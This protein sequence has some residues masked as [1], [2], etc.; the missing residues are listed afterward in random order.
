MSKHQDIRTGLAEPEEIRRTFEVDSAAFGERMPEAVVEA[1]SKWSDP[2]RISVSRDGGDE[3][4]GVAVSIPTAVTLPGL[5]RLTA[6]AVVGVSVLPTHRRQGRLTAMMRHQLD[7]L[8]ERGEP[9]ATLYSSEGSIY[10]R[11]GYG[12]AT[13][14]ARYMIDGRK[15]RLARPIE[16]VAR[17]SMRMVGAAEAREALP[18]L[19]A[20]YAPSRPGEIDALPGEWLDLEGAWRAE[21]AQQ[22]FF[23]LYC[24]GDRVDG[25]VQYRIAGTDPSDPWSRAVFLERFFAVS[26]GAYV[27]LWDFLLGID[28]VDEVRTRGRPVDEPLRWMLVDHRQLRVVGVSDRTWVR[29]IDVAACLAA[30]GYGTEGTLVIDVNDEFCPWNAGRYRLS[31]SAGAASGGD[32]GPGLPGTMEPDSIPATVEFVGTGATGTGGAS[33]AD[34]QLDASTLASSYL[35]GVSLSNLA[36][37]GRVIPASE[38]ALRLA[39]RM[40]STSRPPYCSL[41]I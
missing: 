2:S 19:A 38:E 18:A 17:G 37:A 1:L 4:V 15:A 10:G 14:G 35:G 24:E 11:Y 36:A 29:L 23:A 8:R 28:L 9:L 32:G 6:A 13:F 7:G 39:D 33:G 12:P 30:R 27:A 3:I 31:A 20:D 5:R 26:R 25:A 16:E 41:Q 21:E 34:I 22:R 40:F